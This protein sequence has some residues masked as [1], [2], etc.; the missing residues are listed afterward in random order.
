MQIGSRVMI[1]YP[2]LDFHKRIGTITETI[3]GN[4]DGLKL[5]E[6]H[7]I[8]VDEF[9]VALPAGKFRVLVDEAAQ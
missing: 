1:E 8:A 6:L 2:G 5:G 7:V 4:G 3:D 9:T